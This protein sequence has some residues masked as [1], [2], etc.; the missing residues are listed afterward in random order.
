MAAI[1]RYSK[2]RVLRRVALIIAAALVVL[3]VLFGIRYRHALIGIVRA[4]RL[5][6]QM[7]GWVDLSS[8]YSAPFASFDSKIGTDFELLR[9]DVRARGGDVLDSAVWRVDLRDGK[10]GETWNT[11]DEEFERGR[12][13]VSR[14]KWLADWKAERRGRSIE[15]LVQDDRSHAILKGVQNQMNHVW[16]QFGLRGAPRF[17]VLARRGWSSWIYL[18]FNEDGSFAVA[19]EGVERRSEDLSAHW[20]D[21]VLPSETWSEAGSKVMNFRFTVITESGQWESRIYQRPMQQQDDELEL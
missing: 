21:H 3:G 19:N 15:L 14:Q 11:F 5:A 4:T 2:W 18:T 12:K 10:P 8:K 13:V 16:Q 6:H 17:Y 1:C 20:L 9:I 7:T